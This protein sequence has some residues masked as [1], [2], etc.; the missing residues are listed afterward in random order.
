MVARSPIPDEVTLRDFFEEVAAVAVKKGISVLQEKVYGS[1]ADLEMILNAR[2]VAY[3]KQG[4]KLEVPPTFIEGAPCIGG[5]L[6]GVQIIGVECHSEE[7]RVETI[8]YRGAPVGHE[9]RLPGC[10][11][12]FY[13][14]VSGFDLGADRNVTEQCG[15]MF[16]TAEAM[17]QDQGLSSKDIVRTWI[18][19]A[20]LLDWYGEFNRVRTSCFTRYGILNNDGRG[21]LPASTGIQGKRIAGEEIF[22]DVLAIRSDDAERYQATPMCNVRQN[23]AYDYGSSFSRG[24]AVAFDGKPE[25]WVSGTASINDEGK[26]VHHG[27][28]QNQVVETVLAIAALLEGQGSRLR[29][30]CQATAYCKSDCDYQAFER[31]VD[32]LDMKDIPFVPVLADVCRDEL[33]FEIDSVA[34]KG[35]AQSRDDQ[36]NL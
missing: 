27:D 5:L 34:V 7:A 19:M 16:D 36:L 22:M 32:Y 15:A 25:L 24:M 3:E 10:R 8:R 31:I 13:T 17:L 33:L 28:E 29:D 1:C 20:R 23:E 6:A 35:L 12:L 26:T 2:S 18:Y 4:L 9:L 21:V 30:I 11:K 14:G